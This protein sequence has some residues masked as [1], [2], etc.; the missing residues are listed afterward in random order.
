MALAV[1]TRR[2]EYEK[3]GIFA[4]IVL[5]ASFL[6]SAAS[7]ARGE[8][9]IT[10]TYPYYAFIEDPDNPWETVWDGPGTSQIPCATKQVSLFAPHHE[11]QDLW[12]LFFMLFDKEGMEEAVEEGRFGD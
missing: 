11:N 1:K 10:A 7:F 3:L 8:Q 12:V 5:I 6:F 2:K 9:S 4:A